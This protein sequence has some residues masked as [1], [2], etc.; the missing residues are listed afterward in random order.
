VSFTRF[1]LRQTLQLT[2]DRRSLSAAV[3]LFFSTH[4]C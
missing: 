3:V 4:F 2:A 1:S